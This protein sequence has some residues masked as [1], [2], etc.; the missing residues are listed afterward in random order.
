[1]Q[2]KTYAWAIARSTKDIWLLARFAN[3]SEG[4]IRL[5]VEFI[6]TICLAELGGLGDGV[7][8]S[9]V[10]ENVTGTHVS[11]SQL[12]ELCFGVWDAILMIVVVSFFT[13][14]V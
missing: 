8:A 2:W 11:G 13:K 3:A 12:S 6:A 4:L 5:E 14:K 10:F 1:M 7:A 9:L